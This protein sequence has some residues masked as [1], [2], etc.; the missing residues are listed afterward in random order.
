MLLLLQPS[1]S[2]TTQVSTAGAKHNLQAVSGSQSARE[3]TRLVMHIPQMPSASFGVV[4][5][6]G[7]QCTER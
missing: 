2:K 5:I 7:R 3:R 6:A 1:T 4:A